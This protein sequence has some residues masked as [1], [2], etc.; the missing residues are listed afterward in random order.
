MLYGHGVLSEFTRISAAFRKRLQDRLSPLFPAGRT[1]DEIDQTYIWARTVRCPCC[2]GLVPLS[3]NWRLAPDG[4]GVSLHPDQG[5][6]PGDAN[7]ICRFE[8]VTSLAEQS[9]GTVAGGDGRCPYP[10]CGRVIDGDE[11]KRQ[12]QAGGM[13]E[14]L[15]AVVFKRRVL[16]K[17]KTGRTR[18]KWERGYRAARPEDDV[19]VLVAARLAEKLPEWEAHDIVPNEA[20]G[21]LSNYD[22]GHRMYGMYRWTDMFS[23]RQ[24][25]GHGTS[26]E[27]Y[28]ELLEEEQ[29]KGELGDEVKAAFAYLAVAVDRLIDWNSRQCTWELGK[30]RM[31]HTFHVH[32]FALKWSFCEM[33]PLIT[34]LGYD[35]SIKQTAKCIE[36]LIELTR[37]D[38]VGNGKRNGGAG[39]HRLDLS[40]SNFVPPKIEIT[41]KSADALDHLDGGTVDAVII[42]PPYY[43]NVMYAELSDFFY[44]WLKRTA[45]YVYPEWF[46]RP[47]TDKENEAVANVAKFK[48]RKGGRVLAERDYQD[49]MAA[50]FAECRRVLKPNGIMT[51]MFTH[52]ENAAWDALTRGMMEAGFVITASWPVGTEAEGSL[53]IRDKAAANSTIFLVCRP[54]E[55]AGTNGDGVF[56]EDVEPEV[57]KAVR[58]RIASFEA[59]GIKGVDLYLASFGP[60]LEA[61]SRHWPLR[62]GTPRAAVQARRRRVQK[63]LF[64]EEHDPYAVTP[65]A[66]L[67]AARREVKQWRLQQLTHRQARRGPTWTRRRRGSCSPGT[68]SRRRSSP[69]TRRC[70]WRGCAASISTPR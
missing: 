51:V 60:A 17:T 1:D 67:D 2:E 33:A 53:R 64:P 61:F 44:V 42:D 28:R 24:L 19:S 18:E 46:R 30:L 45:G 29:A 59:A 22:R 15:Y 3:P 50:I 27:V 26:V 7:R 32:G 25:I 62:R 14:Q 52:K 5:T 31:A 43:A 47:L 23:P 58:A 49:R 11:I 8:I 16:A 34:G 4:T 13:G 65:E 40:A 20:I 56:W 54:R 12:A 38:S 10:D 41:C 9:A 68:P 35:W 57:A 36:E 6:G 21:E 39:Q 48:D 55:V 69:M 37:P 66:A 70:G 63:E